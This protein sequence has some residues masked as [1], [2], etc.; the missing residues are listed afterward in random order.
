MWRRRSETNAARSCDLI[1]IP[2]EMFEPAG[3]MSA[4]DAV[5]IVVLL[6]VGDEVVRA[7]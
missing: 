3:K 2:P 1:G 5:D 6:E 7:M 4:A